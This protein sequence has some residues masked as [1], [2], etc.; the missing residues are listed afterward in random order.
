MESHVCGG[1]GDIGFNG[2]WTLEIKVT[3]PTRVLPYFEI[4]QVAFA[5]S[6]GDIEEYGSEGFRSR[7]QGQHDI[8][9]YRGNR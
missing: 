6:T 8:T 3:Y 4:G 5:E 2:T 9:P 7:Y 1:W